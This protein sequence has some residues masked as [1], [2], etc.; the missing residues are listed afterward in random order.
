MSAAEGIEPNA[1]RFRAQRLAGIIKGGGRI[2]KS[3]GTT[4]L[5]FKRFQAKQISEFCMVT[6]PIFVK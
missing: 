4:V 6:S 3:L 5:N 1:L 2:S